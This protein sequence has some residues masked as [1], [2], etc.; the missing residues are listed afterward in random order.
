MGFFDVIFNFLF[1]LWKT[2]I[3]RDDPRI[4]QLSLRRPDGGRHRK[5]GRH[6]RRLFGYASM[7]TKKKKR[8]GKKTIWFG[9]Y[10]V[11]KP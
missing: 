8:D 4:F 6:G 1:G 9:Y 2:R 7:P 10:F 3:E 11:G 5:M